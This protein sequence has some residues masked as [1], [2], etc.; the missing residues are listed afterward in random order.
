MSGN[1]LLEISL[2]KEIIMIDHKY[3]LDKLRSFMKKENID[4]Y[5]VNAT[6]EYLNEYIDLEQNS[7]YLLTGFSGSTGD[8][9]ISQDKAFL[10]V[11]GRYHL[12]ADNQTD[13]NLITV[14]KLGLGISQQQALT[15]KLSEMAHKHQTIGLTSSKISYANFKKLKSFIDENDLKLKE[16]L[17]DPVLEIA[18]MHEVKSQNSLR[19][20]P[21][22]IAGKTSGEKLDIAAQK[23]ELENTDVFIVSK[24]E[25]IAYLTNLRGS[26]IHFSS[27]FKAIAIITADFASQENEC[28]IF[29]D[30][31]KI[32]PEIKEKFDT[33]FKFYPEEQFKS[34]LKEMRDL[35]VVRNI[36]FDPNSINL[37]TYRLLEQ[38][39]NILREVTGSPIA[40]IKSIKNS[41]ELD[42]MK[43]C[44]S[45]TDLVVDKSIFYNFLTTSRSRISFKNDLNCSSG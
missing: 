19:F 15:E 44:F 35:E 29:T 30:I 34:F 25:E 36:G 8:A 1:M 42:H 14:V 20:I 12:Q 43:Y 40:L 16:L 38:G 17:I 4:L 22:D 27:S 23:M 6:D 33:R 10:F 31:E 39:N 21:I 7:R 2:K 41:S 3:M 32:S 37:L 11:D 13:E 28:Q 5:I 26:D 24:L 45:K 9:L 18:D